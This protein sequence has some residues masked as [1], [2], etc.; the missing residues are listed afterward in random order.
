ME[1]QLLKE[2]AKPRLKQ[3]QK[4]VIKQGMMSLGLM[5]VIMN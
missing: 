4:W 2:I 1:L 5:I 3:T